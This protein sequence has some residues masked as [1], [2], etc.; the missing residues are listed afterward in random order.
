MLLANAKQ[1]KIMEEIDANGIST[2]ARKGFPKNSDH[3]LKE[4]ICD[5]FTIFQVQSFNC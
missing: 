1:P 5:N 4:F 2:K 3:I